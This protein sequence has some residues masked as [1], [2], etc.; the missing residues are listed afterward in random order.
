[1]FQVHRS[2]L[3]GN[4]SQLLPSLY[5]FL[6]MPV[7][8]WVYQSPI[9]LLCDE[10]TNFSGPTCLGEIPENIFVSLDKTQ[11]QAWSSSPGTALWIDECISALSFSLPFLYLKIP[12]SIRKVSSLKITTV[13]SSIP[14]NLGVTASFLSCTYKVTSNFINKFKSDNRKDSYFPVVQE[15]DG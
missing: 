7:V 11:C 2:F 12:F 14:N 4:D 9:T 15:K 5:V 10:C 6:C 3:S 8:S 1:M 13:F